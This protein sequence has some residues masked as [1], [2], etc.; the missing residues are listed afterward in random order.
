MYWEYYVYIFCS[1]LASFETEKF[2]N[3][4]REENLTA[5]VVLKQKSFKMCMRKI[6]LQL[7]EFWNRKVS[8]FCRRRKFSSGWVLK[9]KVLKMCMRKISLQLGEFW[10]RKVSKF[11][12]RR[13]FRSSWGFE[14]EKFQNGAWE[15]CS[16]W[17]SLKSKDFRNCNG[18]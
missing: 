17:S 16:G 12:M 8:K 14:T 9:Q 7:G 1:S 5:A 10:N 18:N 15:N 13:K 3:F 4:V 6:S 2:Q 11:C